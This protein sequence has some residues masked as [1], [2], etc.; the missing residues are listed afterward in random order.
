[1][2]DEKPTV[3]LVLSSGGARG[4]A[5]IGAI[6]VLE[7]E[8]YKI[9]AIS[10]SSIGA[11]IG[12]CYAAGHLQDYKEWISSLNQF[13]VFKL[14]D[15]TIST[16]GLIKGQRVFNILEELIGNPLIEDLPIPFTA[17]ATDL[18]QRQ[19]VWFREGNL[20]KAIRA[21]VSIPTLI[22]PHY[23]DGREFIDG[24]VLNP[25]PIDAG[26]QADA[27]YVIAVNLNADIPYQKPINYRNNKS[28]QET[29]ITYL[30][31]RFAERW[32]LFTNQKPQSREENFSYL[33]LISS[34]F[35]L[36]NIRMTEMILERSQ[37]DLIIPV[38]GEACA[39]MEFYRSAEMIEAGREATQK[40]LA[41]LPKKT[42][43]PADEQ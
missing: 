23:H 27:D 11:A 13:D 9:K 16:Q 29:S 21:S 3:S 19:E 43:T 30:F 22:T 28:G 18:R 41:S 40:A 12:G 38:S 24:G 32:Q 39:T 14:M 31:N 25:L 5:Q 4:N 8:G 7:E 6:E 37:P 35:N 10:G 15:F 1:M 26:N 17:V 36:M 33:N 20:L 42:C 2:S 34:T